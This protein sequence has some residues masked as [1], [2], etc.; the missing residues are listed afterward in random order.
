MPWVCCAFGNVYYLISYKVRAGG[1]WVEGGGGTWQSPGADGLRPLL[2]ESD[3]QCCCRGQV[4]PLLIAQA[5]LS[6]T[7][8]LHSCATTI[9][10]QLLHSNLCWSAISMA[11]VRIVNTFSIGRMVCFSSAERQSLV[12]IR[13]MI[14]SLGTE[15]IWTRFL[16][17]T[18]TICDPLMPQSVKE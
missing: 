12:V 16:F 11:A 4:V 18:K 2:S 14:I 6:S 3:A 9:A 13:L 10:Q 7:S 17:P 8:V 15:G 5:T 1:G